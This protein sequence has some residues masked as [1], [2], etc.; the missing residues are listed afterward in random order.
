[1]TIR[2]RA[3]D[4]ASSHLRVSVACFR[5]NGESIE[6]IITDDATLPSAKPESMETL[7][8]T[9]KRIIHSS[10]AMAAAYIEQL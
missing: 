10:F 4:S 8:A 2:M 3:Q 1:M 7:D 5:W 9:A 6:T